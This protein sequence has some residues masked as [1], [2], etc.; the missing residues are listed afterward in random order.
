V[1]CA[2]TRQGHGF[3]KPILFVHYT[4]Y[5]CH[6]SSCFASHPCPVLPVIPVPV[7]VTPA[8]VL[9]VTP[10]PACVTSHSS[11]SSSSDTWSDHKGAHAQGPKKRRPCSCHYCPCSSSDSGP[12]TKAPLPYPTIPTTGTVI[13]DTFAPL[14]FP[15]AAPSPFGSASTFLCYSSN[16]FIVCQIWLVFQKVLD[17]RVTERGK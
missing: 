16:S 12:V 6:S 14:M 9:P 4:S 8:P 13:P 17:N 10:A 11:S 7:T 3:I 1:C 15:T 5:C 2:C